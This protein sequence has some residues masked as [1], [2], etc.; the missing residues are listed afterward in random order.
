MI[1]KVKNLLSRITMNCL[2]NTMNVRVERD[3]QQGRVFIQ[4][5]Y[6]APC[7]KTG[8]LQ[9]FRGRKWYLSQ[10]MTSDEIVK[11]AYCAFKMCVEHE[12]MEGFKV[13]NIIVFN[14]HVDFEELLKISH[15]EVKRD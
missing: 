5:T 2:G 12:I 1:T 11:T 6:M 4:V 15:K 3:G 13:D 10:Y 8:T 14:P 9:E 7:T